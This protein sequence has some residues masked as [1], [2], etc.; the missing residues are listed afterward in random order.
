MKEKEKKKTKKKT[1]KEIKTKPTKLVVVE[2]EGRHSR[3]SDEHSRRA[4]GSSASSGGGITN[5]LRWFKRPARGS[6]QAQESLTTGRSG[7]GNELVHSRSLDNGH[8]DKWRGATVAVKHQS[9]M[10]SGS[11]HS[12]CDSL[13]TASSFAFI[14]TPESPGLSDGGSRMQS[15]NRFRSRQSESTAVG[16]GNLIRQKYGLYADVEEMHPDSGEQQIEGAAIRAM[17]TEWESQMKQMEQ[18]RTVECETETNPFYNNYGRN[19]KRPAPPPPVLSATTATTPAPSKRSSFI[20]VPGKRRAP[21]PPPPSIP[22]S[23]AVSSFNIPVIT[24]PITS[25]ISSLHTRETPSAAAAAAVD[26]D[27]DANAASNVPDSPQTSETQLNLL[28]DHQLRQINN[29]S[30][31]PSSPKFQNKFNQPPSRTDVLEGAQALLVDEEPHPKRTPEWDTGNKWN[32][33]SGNLNGNQNTVLKT[34]NKILLEDSTFDA[35]VTTESTLPVSRKPLTPSNRLVNHNSDTPVACP[36]ITNNVSAQTTNDIKVNVK[37]EARLHPVLTDPQPKGIQ[38]TSV[39]ETGPP[40]SNGIL[41]L[42]DGI[43]RPV[44]GAVSRPH[45]QEQRAEFG[46]SDQKQRRTL[47]LKPWYK[48]H[49][50]KIN[51][52]QIPADGEDKAAQRNIKDSSASFHERLDEWMPEVPYFRRSLFPTSKGNTLGRKVPLVRSGS[53]GN[54]SKRKSLLV[55]ISQLDREAEEI[56]RKEREK[57]LQRKRVE[58]EQFYTL[59]KQAS[60]PSAT[61]S[62]EN[63]P[64]SNTSGTSNTSD[65]PEEAPPTASARQLINMF[66]SF[67]KTRVTVNPAFGAAESAQTKLEPDPVGAVASLKIAPPESEVA[68][69]SQPNIQISITSN[70]TQPQTTITPS[71]PLESLMMQGGGGA[72][73]KRQAVYVTVGDKESDER[74]NGLVEGIGR[75]S[76]DEGWTCHICTL[77]NPNTR[78]LCNACTAL[79][80]HPAISAAVDSKKSKTDHNSNHLVTSKPAQVTPS[81]SQGNTSYAY[82]KWEDELKKYFSRPM[83]QTAQPNASAPSQVSVDKAMPNKSYQSYAQIERRTQSQ[84]IYPETPTPTSLPTP[85]PTENLTQPKSPVGKKNATVPPVPSK[86]ESHKTVPSDTDA[87]QT[88]QSQKDGEIKAE[89]PDPEALRQA[90]LNFFSCHS[91][92]NLQSEPR[93]LNE[94]H[95]R[96]GD[97]NHTPPMSPKGSRKTV[98]HHTKLSSVN[99]S[100][101]YLRND[102]KTS[103]EVKQRS[104]DISL[105][106]PVSPKAVRKTESTSSGYTKVSSGCQTN[107]NSLLKLKNDASKSNQTAMSAA[108][109]HSNPST[110]FENDASSSNSSNSSSLR[111]LLISSPSVVASTITDVDEIANCTSSLQLSRYIQQRELAARGQPTFANAQSMS[112]YS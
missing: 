77:L 9:L 31:Q 1:K 70:R 69:R 32:D 93:V 108:V 56:I 26:D 24:P 84:V 86:D 88:D 98:P 104:N 76:S 91:N 110:R 3:R 52:A 112:Q 54:H 44:G 15:I 53:E 4:E 28:P 80:P 33:L 38:S 57:A 7:E 30:N 35:S 92:V 90:R 34:Q 95:Q 50:S 20:H 45:E 106:P 64:D 59:P 5:I 72:R 109:P 19:K 21:S 12:L 11:G 41:K 73:P 78:L 94:V 13:S 27:D 61:A 36:I 16:N 102:A 60:V 79:K 8:S 97:I 83:S 107:I 25:S 101:A 37:V 10:R 62:V 75:W 66:N 99:K 111:R 105:L 23:I 67:N 103:N 40:N 71:A 68:S 29:L 14:R 42:E 100:V 47:P 22:V 74:L 17:R 55:N 6:L 96:N 81:L 2:Q 39:I 58:N 48:R 49:G 65:D 46:N 89:V 63:I 18:C 51:A 87:S 85:R 43:L 82:L